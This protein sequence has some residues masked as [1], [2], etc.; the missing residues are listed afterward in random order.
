MGFRFFVPT[1]CRVLVHETCLPIKPL[2]FPKTVSVVDAATNTEST[3]E[4]VDVGTCTQLTSMTVADVATCTKPTV[5]L[6]KDAAP[7]TEPTTAE[8][9][10][11]DT[12]IEQTVAAA[13][14]VATDMERNEAENDA[15][16]LSPAVL[17]VQVDLEEDNGA[18]DALAVE[19]SEYEAYERLLSSSNYHM[20]ALKVITGFIIRLRD[21]DDIPLVY[22]D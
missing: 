18:G 13:T 21:R 4:T 6:T 10:E 11:V 15:G 2:G 22:S 19:N 16:D 5:V 1:G 9:V 8:T 17:P 20:S 12:I 14:D 3:G 7:C